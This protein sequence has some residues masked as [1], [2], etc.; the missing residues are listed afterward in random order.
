MVILSK[1][2]RI[3]QNRVVGMSEN[4]SYRFRWSLP[5]KIW[6]KRVQTI[7]KR[8]ALALFWYRLSFFLFWSFFAAEPSQ[9][10]YQYSTV[11]SVTRDMGGEI[12]IL[13]YFR[14]QMPSEKSLGHSFDV[15]N[16][17]ESIGDGFRSIRHHL[18]GQKYENHENRPKSANFSR[19]WVPLSLVT[20]VVSRLVSS[21]AD[22][23]VSSRQQLICSEN[24][25]SVP[26]FKWTVLES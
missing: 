13:L 9:P 4:C 16:H 23:F 11:Q 8:S 22:I 25:V 18:G 26:N 14:A 24:P 20:T 15:K 6:G 5:F 21:V 1:S 12:I 10:L 7:C 3:G 17:Q 2:P 19:S